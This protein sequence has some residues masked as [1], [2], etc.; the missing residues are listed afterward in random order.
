[1][2]GASLGE[3]L[4]LKM[5]QIREVVIPAYQSI[6]PSGELAIMLMNAD[7]TKAEQA[8]AAGDIAGMIEAYR[9]LEEYEL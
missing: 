6:G 5:K 8:M 2:S 9:S 3:A 1:M 7:L 4:P